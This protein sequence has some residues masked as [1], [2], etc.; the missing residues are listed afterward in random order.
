[1]EDYRINTIREIYKIFLENDFAVSDFF[2]ENSFAFDIIAKRDEEVFVIK[3]VYNIDTLKTSLTREIQRFTLSLDVMAMVIG[4][5]SG[6]GELEDGIL[7]FRHR[8]PIMNLATFRNYM[9]GI[10]PDIYSGPGGYYV[11]IDGEKMQNARLSRGYSIGYISNKIGL[12]RRSVSLYE[13]GSSTTVDVFDKLTQILRENISKPMDLRKISTEWQRMDEEYVIVNRKFFINVLTAMNNMGLAMKFFTR[14]PFD[15]VAT[16][17][18]S[19]VYLTGL[20]DEPDRIMN[21]VSLLRSICNIM[22]RE[23]LIISEKPTDKDFIAGCPVVTI[24]EIM[25]LGLASSVE[26]KI[27]K[28]DRL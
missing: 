7:Y 24:K 11:P 20:S 1:V 23:P 27:R 2:A 14:F 19:N 28:M 13:S 16:S 10:K 25:E 5:R 21:N 18:D 26:K 3:V 22:E 15:A 6:S 12:S 17:E 4:S 8:M 9:K